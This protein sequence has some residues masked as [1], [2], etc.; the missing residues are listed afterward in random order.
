[1]SESSN[2]TQASVDRLRATAEALHAIYSESFDVLA[3]A[4]T[5]LGVA[6]ANRL[7]M[8]SNLGSI[9]KDLGDA[10][11]AAISAA[12]SG[13]PFEAAAERVGTLH[14]EGVL[15]DLA[16]KRF[17]AFEFRDAQRALLAAKLDMLE[18]QHLSESAR[19]D[20]HVAGIYQS[21]GEAARADG[22]LKVEMGGSTEGLK[23]V[24]AAIRQEAEAVREEITLHDIESRDLRVEYERQEDKK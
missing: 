4:E 24:L 22:G 12:I 1:M 5:A 3:A 16:L 9:R 18:K 23:R 13:V 20:A 6:T 17:H 19:K 11:L 7:R 14:N 8:V 21:L 15:I 10:R 2:I